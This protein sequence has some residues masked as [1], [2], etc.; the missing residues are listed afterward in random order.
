MVKKIGLLYMIIYVYI[1]ENKGANCIC[2][3]DYKEISVKIPDVQDI[4]E[5]GIVD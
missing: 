5:E 3:C 1:F 2:F 4:K